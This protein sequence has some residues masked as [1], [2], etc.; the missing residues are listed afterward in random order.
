MA[1]ARLTTKWRIFR[2]NL[3]YS[4]KKSSLIC[5]VA[6]KL[7]N[8]V[9]QED[10][11]RFSKSQMISDF[12]VDRIPSYPGVNGI[13]NVSPFNK[14]YLAPLPVALNISDDS[15]RKSIGDDL[16]ILK[17]CRPKDNLLRNGES[18]EEE[19]DQPQIVEEEDYEFNEKDMTI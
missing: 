8:F 7:H 12:D 5:V 1:F 9:I 10:K 19:N 14:G 2:C 18:L 6:G 16:C 4:V 17:I 11:P 13:T 3:S 15:R